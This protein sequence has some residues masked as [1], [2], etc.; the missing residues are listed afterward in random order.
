[1]SSLDAMVEAVTSE[2]DERKDD[3][4]QSREDAWYFSRWAAIAERLD[5]DEADADLVDKSF[6]RR[7]LMDRLFGIVVR[8]LLD[9][10]DD[11]IAAVAVDGA[12]NV[13][14]LLLLLVLSAVAFILLV[15]TVDEREHMMELAACRCVVFLFCVLL[16]VDRLLVCSVCVRWPKHC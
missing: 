4:D 2:P 9:D 1:M 6:V 3:R 8:L 14:F 5:M 12:G 10:D 15:W 7:P 16:G 13:S 11:G